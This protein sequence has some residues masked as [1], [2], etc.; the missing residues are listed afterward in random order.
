MTSQTSKTIRIG[1]SQLENR[2][3]T[4]ENARIIADAMTRWAALGADLVAF[5]ECALTGFSARPGA[6]DAE[7]LGH[8]LDALHKRAIALGVSALIPSARRD[9]AGGVWN[10]AWALGADGSRARFDKQGLT[11]SERQFFQAP[12]APAARAFTHGPLRLGLL[13]CREVADPPEVHIRADDVDV[14]LWP[15]YWAWGDTMRWDAPEGPLHQGAR[16]CLD[17]WRRPMLQI[18][19]AGNALDDPR[20]GS[21]DGRSVVI[22]PQNTLIH[23][24]P[25]R[26]GCGV[27][28][29]LARPQPDDAWAITTCED[30]AL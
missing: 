21:P 13:F 11:D 18:N 19:F 24:G 3:D 9:D 5:P 10:S 16:A 1:L 15:A 23:Q 17:A 30:V 4:A 26:A 8:T 14:V 6:C 12:E 27:L 28:V 25:P 22:S 2:T 29:T 7:T 20:P